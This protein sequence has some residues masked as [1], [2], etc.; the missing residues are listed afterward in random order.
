MRYDFTIKQRDTGHPIEAYL[1]NED[2][3]AINLTDAAVEFVM[4][5]VGTVEAVVSASATIVTPATGRVKYDWLEA[6][7]A[8]AGD[9][10]AHWVV[11][12]SSGAVLTVPSGGYISILV[13]EAMRGNIP[14]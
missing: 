1:Q 12:L 8:V 9:Y 2:G 13:A 5:R 14:N 4:R 11:T 7:T 3:T 6:D 10:A